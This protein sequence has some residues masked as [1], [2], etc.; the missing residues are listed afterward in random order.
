MGATLVSGI[1]L[2]K[3]TGDPIGV[4]LNSL[5][6][7]NDRATES[8]IP[9]P[10]E[11]PV[12]IAL[13]S[14]PTN[15]QAVST[16][17]TPITLQPV[18][19]LAPETP[20]PETQIDIT[21]TV[22]AFRTQSAEAF[23]A[24]ATAFFDS[25]AA[26]QSTPENP[27]MPPPEIKFVRGTWQIKSAVIPGGMSRDINGAYLAVCI[28]NGTCNMSG[29]TEDD[30][31]NI[32][33]ASDNINA[34]TGLKAQY[35]D[36]DL[37][38]LVH[39]PSGSD[40][41]ELVISGYKF[42]A[43][44]NSYTAKTTNGAEVDITFVQP[45]AKHNLAQNGIVK[46]GRDRFIKWFDRKFDFNDTQK[47]EEGAWWITYPDGTDILFAEG[48]GN[49]TVSKLEEHMIPTPGAAQPP[50]DTPAPFKPANTPVGTTPGQP[51]ETHTSQPTGTTFVAT[52]TQKPADTPR[53]TNTH[54]EA[55]TQ[56]PQG[57]METDIPIPGAG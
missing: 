46:N 20:T 16:E 35:G 25:L 29:L 34:S 8:Y 36:I 53:P 33:A 44:Q 38:T 26:S 41:G 51:Q 22:E 43:T 45:Q 40:Y 49:F 11:T 19:T 55:N 28:V 12:E 2:N 42:D 3:I 54:S 15:V 50:M 32:R 30:L 23:N 13:V 18:A 5:L 14:T 21:G 10:T 31:A 39:D 37:S 47:L 52:G 1:V 7:N 6:N 48:C 9:D 27:I 17:L 57:N 24:S 4:V 56:V